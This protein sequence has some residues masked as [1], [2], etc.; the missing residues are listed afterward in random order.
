MAGNVRRTGASPE[1]F[2]VEVDTAARL[3]ASPSSRWQ[4]TVHPRSAFWIALGQVAQDSPTKGKRR[5]GNFL[6]DL[7]RRIWRVAFGA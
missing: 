3:A 2:V 1:Q 5:G 7:G 6:A 4:R